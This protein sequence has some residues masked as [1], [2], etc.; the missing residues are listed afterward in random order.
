MPL[1][2][3]YGRIGSG[4]TSLCMQ[5]ALEKDC[6]VYFVTPEQFTFTAEKR[7]CAKV[8]VHGLSGVEVLSFKRLALRVLS[9]Y[10]G[11]ALP[12]IDA[13]TKAILLQKILVESASKLS[14]LTSFTKEPGSVGAL[15]KILG[16]LKR[17]SITP[18]K[19]REIAELLPA[20]RAKLLDIA[21][22]FE[23]YEA[24]I[25]DRFLDRDDDMS[26][27]LAV[28]SKENPLQGTEVYLD[29]FD[30]FDASELLAI[31]AMLQNGIRVTVT[32]AMR[33]EDTKKPAFSL[34]AKMAKRLL[35]IA[36]SC[37]AEIEK[38][39]ILTK[40]RVAASG[41][42]K[43]CEAYVSYP[44]PPMEGVPEGLALITAQN[45]LEEVH[46]AARRILELCRENGY[47]YRDVAIT[48]RNTAS[49]ERY[50][51]A[52]L[53][54]YGIPFFMDRTIN[55]LEHPFTVFILSAMEV[56]LHG[57]NYESMFRYIKS[58][59]LRLPA[60]T[61][62]ALEN[63]VLAT[64]IRGDIW[65][66]EEKWNLKLSAYA[67]RESETET[68]LTEIADATRRKIMAPL[69]AFGEALKNGKTAYQKCEAIYSFLET[70]KT[71]RRV[72]ALCKLFEKRGDYASSSEFRGVY[73]DFMDALDGVCDA[74]GDENI[75][76]RR[77]YE[78][79][80]AAL[81]EFETG[82]IPSSQD[83]V[84]VGSIDRI[85][86]YD[87][88]ALLV[89]G[90]E[91]GVFPAVPE[92]GGILN[93]DERAAFSALGADFPT[94][95]NKTRAEE[96]HL[97]YKCMTIPTEILEFSY[98]AAGM[99]GSAKR[100]SCIFTR[101]MEIFPEVS[102]YNM[103]LGISEEDKISVPQITLRYLLSALKTGTASPL[104]LESYG[105]LLEKLP[106]ETN[107]GI[108]HLF[109]ENNAEKLSEETVKAYMED[110]LFQS[111]SRLE[112]L[113]GCPFSY[114]T[115]YILGAKERRIMEPGSSDAGRF[116]HD[117]IDIFSRRL[118]ENGKAW[119]DVD[120]EY[121]DKEFSEIVPMLDR[122]L[123]PFMLENSPRFVHLFARLR[124]A[125]RTGIHMLSEHMKKCSFEPLGYELSFG[126]GGDLAP[127]TFRLPN[128]REVK[129]SGRID[130]ADILQNE[131]GNFVRIIDYKSGAKTF[132]LD[133]V[134]DG[135]NLQ[136]AVYISAL[137]SEDN[138]TLLGEN[139]KPGGILYF[140]FVDPVVEAHP[141]E[142]TAVLEKMQKQK[143]KLSG[144]LVNDEELLKAMD[145]G[146]GASSDVL[147]VR[148]QSTGVRGSVAS[149]QQ[150]DTLDAYVKK[151][152]NRLLTALSEGNI[153]IS[154]YKK[155]DMSAC[156][157][158]KYA[159]FCAHDGSRFRHLEKTKAEEIWQA[160]EAETCK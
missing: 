103:L 74:F 141:E 21:V 57:C 92:K 9:Q 89:L 115:T 52:V 124:K 82:I 66:S 41:I 45:P 8:N 84:S 132:E 42:S 62:D 146:I 123:S 90:T 81:G 34:H 102:H 127:L 154:P 99:E 75:S 122:R 128:G 35:D 97:V 80:K 126:E 131:K 61:V 50:I 157:Y 33:P 87:V 71:R 2:L 120:E 39:Q 40:Q 116:L 114:Y 20:S 93:D 95:E 96:E 32:V 51:E 78:I 1:R 98:S 134:Y 43:L 125:V 159:A 26:R 48:A 28:L 144:L 147:P 142:E 68:E 107:R 59:F 10:D 91:D 7:L 149:F 69:I 85:K 67:E 31:G 140:R 94:A 72:L 38:P 152:V 139:V 12:R 77:L 143:F 46:R 106:E 88:K 27:F 36:A 133:D 3:I 158:C 44:V 113:A 13:R 16:E 76:I 137:C 108:K 100:P 60:D 37:G 15:G 101:I 49:Y 148:I 5:E 47:L 119:K 29:R 11:A 104:L 6:P 130:R 25:R 150:F 22:L 155:G 112:K 24:A 14:A 65:K 64:G 111:V 105:W 138:A 79:L 30:G 19:L 55:I 53:P 151:T 117:F 63:Y 156:T 86:G 145:S 58:G 135:L 109:V 110:T 153:G 83:G 70:M 136:L 129:L 18:E 4:K 23:N 54:M 121:T 73:N 17:Y 160:M 56:L 118:R